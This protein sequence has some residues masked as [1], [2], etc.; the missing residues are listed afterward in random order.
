VFRIPKPDVPLA[1]PNV[2]FKPRGHEHACDRSVVAENVPHIRANE[3]PQ[4]RLAGESDDASCTCPCGRFQDDQNIPAALRTPSAHSELDFDRTPRS[5]SCPDHIEH[6][7][8]AGC[9][10][11][12]RLFIGLSHKRPAAR[13]SAA[14]GPTV[15]MGTRIQL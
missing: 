2:E 15:V 6:G 9:V 12:K 3:T 13:T 8:E 4:R 1:L 7:P 5:T 10:W 11:Q 14:G